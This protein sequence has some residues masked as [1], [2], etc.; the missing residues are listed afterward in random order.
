MNHLTQSLRWSV[1]TTGNCSAFSTNRLHWEQLYQKGQNPNLV[2][3]LTFT[4]LELTAVPLRPSGDG[5][6]LMH[7]ARYMYVDASDRSTDYIA[8]AKIGFFR[9]TLETADNKPSSA[10]SNPSRG[11]SNVFFPTL[12]YR[13]R[14]DT[15]LCPS[16]ETNFRHSDR[17]WWSLVIHFKLFLKCTWVSVRHSWLASDQQQRKKF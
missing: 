1:N 15:H 12:T 7:S 4:L 11:C 9:D 10:R 14:D 8:A 2:I 17:K 3:M 13:R 6:N 5:P 16:F